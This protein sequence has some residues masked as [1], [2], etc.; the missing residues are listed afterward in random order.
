MINVDK[1]IERDRYDA[2]A[3]LEIDWAASQLSLGSKT[4]PLY[5]R[6]PYLQY[7]RL[8]AQNVG[9][10]CSC[11]EIGAGTGMHTKALLDTGASIVISDISQISLD[12]VKRKFSGEY[13]NFE[14]KVA[15]IESLPFPDSSFDAIFCAGSLSYGEP[16]KVN[17]EIRRVLRNGGFLIFIDSLGHNPIF[18][19]NRWLHYLRNNRT[20]STLER[21]PTMS[22]IEELS[23]GFSSVSVFYFGGFIYLCPVIKFFFGE[24]SAECLS[25]TLDSFLH[26]KKSAFKFVLLSKN[27]SKR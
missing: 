1:N 14:T 12:V 11:L 15:D 19:L 18:R 21:I 22:R 10:S 25:D 5:L 2:R 24:A 6:S 13:K 4:M 20:K 16:Y 7:E 9:K 23:T 17:R 8:I 26:V 27:Y 3:S